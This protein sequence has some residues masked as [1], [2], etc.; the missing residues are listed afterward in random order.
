[1]KGKKLSKQL[2]PHELNFYFYFDDL[3]VQYNIKAER[4]W[5]NIGVDLGVSL[6]MFWL[7]YSTRS[8]TLLQNRG[9]RSASMSTCRLV[10]RE[11]PSNRTLFSIRRSVTLEYQVPG[12]TSITRRTEC[13]VQR[14]LFVFLGNGCCVRRRDGHVFFVFGP[15]ASEHP[16]STPYCTSTAII[17]ILAGRTRYSIV[18]E[19]RHSLICLRVHFRGE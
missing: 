14:R 11:V 5:L 6:I 3:I 10:F 8:V 7:L 9:V 13:V 4:S 1:M 12:T 15:S 17:L 18:V 19:S 2:V 16:Y